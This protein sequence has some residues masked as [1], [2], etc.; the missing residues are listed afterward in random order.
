LD[1]AHIPGFDD[2]KSDA[3]VL[4]AIAS[5]FQPAKLE[6]LGETNA[7]SAW[8]DPLVLRL[9]PAALSLHGRVL[10]HDGEPV[11]NATVH[12][13]DAEHFGWIAHDDG[14]M[15]FTTAASVE[16]LASGEKWSSDAH[17]DEH[18]EFTLR[19]LQS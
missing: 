14:G 18:G 12:N 10:T 16:T 5:G 11:K 8:P 7:K 3:R 17:T 9:G 15:H 2:A 13:L 19:G 6:C 4:R 1:L